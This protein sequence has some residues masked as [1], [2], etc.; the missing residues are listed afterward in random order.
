MLGRTEITHHL[1][2]TNRKNNGKSQNQTAWVVSCLEYARDNQSVFSID[3]LR[4]YLADSKRKTLSPDAIINAIPPDAATLIDA[5]DKA[6][7][8]SVR[9]GDEAACTITARYGKAP[10]QR[11]FIVRRAGD[12]IWLRRMKIVEGERLMGFP[13]DYTRVGRMTPSPGP[14]DH[15]AD[16]LLKSRHQAH[17]PGQIA[18]YRIKSYDLSKIEGLRFK[19]LGNSMAVPVVGWLAEQIDGEI[20]HAIERGTFSRDENGVIPFI[21]QNDPELLWSQTATMALFFGGAH[22]ARI[23]LLRLDRLLKYKAAKQEE[24]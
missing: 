20:R 15:K 17:I 18:K 14:D 22:R 23:N 4:N 16:N 8:F 2:N 5:N 10:S 1:K 19:V 13:D 24:N 21:D 3:D 7:R 6:G 9:G 11:P 12:L